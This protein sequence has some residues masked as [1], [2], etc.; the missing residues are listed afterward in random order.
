MK[1]V[2][3]DL[4]G[5]LL[6]MDQE[7]FIKRYLKEL[8]AKGAEWGYGAQELVQIVLKGVDAMV[9]ND[10]TM[11]NE[12]RFWE[13]F[14]TTYG[15]EREE[16]IAVFE[17]FYHN[18]FTRVAEGMNP[19]P[20]SNEA[21]QVLKKKGYEL[22]LATNPVFPRVATLERMRWAGLNSE[23]FTLITTYENS[24]FAKP[25]LDYYR[26]ILTTI[27]AKPEECLMVG[28]DVQE[29]VSVAQ[30][31]MDVFLVTDDLIN[32]TGEDYSHLPQGDRQA[33]VDYLKVL[34]SKR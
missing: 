25:N 16:H 10:G 22:V 31:G 9:A 32:A 29:D 4:D 1:A 28:N 8:G 12:E 3:F 7:V 11:T 6:P 23:D 24:S 19:A 27:N 17:A 33:M 26:E 18:E 14:M 30:L 13:L 34:P 20:L 21:I 2:L 15:G 5:T